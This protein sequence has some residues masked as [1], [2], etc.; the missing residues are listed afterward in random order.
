M[1][2]AILE[3]REATPTRAVAR[4]TRAQLRHA[5]AAGGLTLGLI[6][7][8]WYGHHWWTVDRFLENTDDAF[9]GGDIVA[10][11]P[12][13]AGLVAR[14]AVEDNQ[15]VRAGDLL[16]QLDDRD[17]RAA[18]ARAEGAVAAAEAS[19]ANLDATRR[20][21]DA[22]V[23]QARADV[24]AAAA[25]S[26]RARADAER[27]RAL[28]RSS[29]ASAQRQ[30]Q[31]EADDRKAQADAAKTKAALTAAEREVEVIDTRK[32][33]AQA[34]LQQATAER[35]L[36]RINL[37]DTEIR[38]PVD[39]TVGN[40]SARAG[41]YAAAGTQLL[42]LVPAHGLWVDANFKENQLAALRPGEIATVVA[43]VLP[44]ETFTGRVASLSP[45]TGAQFS[46]LPAE[47]ATGNF[48]R[49]VQRV[50][51]RILLDG[52]GARLGRLR[53]GLSVTASVD[54][55]DPARTAD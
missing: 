37:G 52:D 12:R 34:A 21:Q 22:L 30:Q 45:A 41:A 14:V 31:A 26:E 29:Y 49:I 38:A 48:T 54:L 4:P 16:V 55:R 23:D 7:G 2:S 44:G 51:V 33:E 53:P 3:R 6:T 1:S 39:G 20:L 36:T 32:A 5:L 19:L 17:Y 35:D 25:E 15:A 43:D 24:V 40:R 46:V 27:Y 13:V 8:T 18:L 11:A 10:L 50:P 28:A 9:V 42:A 47:N